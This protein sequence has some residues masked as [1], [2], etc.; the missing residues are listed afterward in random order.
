MGV[1]APSKMGSQFDRKS[2]SVFA[3]RRFFSFRNGAVEKYEKE[4]SVIYQGPHKIGTVYVTKRGVRSFLKRKCLFFGELGVEYFYLVDEGPLL[5]FS[6]SHLN[7]ILPCFSKIN[8]NNIIQCLVEAGR[9]WSRRGRWGREKGALKI[10]PSNMLPVD[11][12]SSHLH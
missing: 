11:I 3:W 1:E 5:E 8:F 10:F 7:D 9:S 2:Y 4:H 12:F 6:S